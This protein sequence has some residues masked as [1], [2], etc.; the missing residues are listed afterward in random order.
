M[1][2]AKRMITVPRPRN[3]IEITDEMAWAGVRALESAGLFLE[4]RPLDRLAECAGEVFAAMAA[5]SPRRLKTRRVRQ[6]RSR[7]L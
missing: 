7:A 3:L 2:A 6:R 5:A 1:K 4:D